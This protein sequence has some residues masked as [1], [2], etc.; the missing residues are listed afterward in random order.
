MKEVTL[1]IPDEKFDFFMELVQEL[2]IDVTEKMDIPEEHKS[3]VR[4]RIKKSNKDPDRLID[5]DKAKDS[6]KID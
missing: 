5:W 1:K 2:G 6:F 3:I 4:E